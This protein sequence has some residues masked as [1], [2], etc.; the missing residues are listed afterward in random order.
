LRLTPSSTLAYLKPAK[1]AIGP[2]AEQQ[3]KHVALTFR[4]LARQGERLQTDIALATD[5]L[6]ARADSLHPGFGEYGEPA[7]LIYWPLSRTN[8]FQGLLY[9]RGWDHGVAAMPVGDFEVMLEANSD[10]P[11]ICH[12]H[13]LASI[14][15]EQ[16]LTHFKSVLQRLKSQGK[17]ILWTAHNVLPHDVTDID[18]ALR[19]RRAMVEAAD[20]IHIMNPRTEEI[21]APHYTFAA[22]P[23]FHSPHP[24]YAGDQPDTVTRA[25]AR[26][27]LGLS[28]QT[29]VFLSFGSIQPYKGLDDLL[30]AALRLKRDAP[31]LD[32][33]LLIAGEEAKDRGPMLGK[34]PAMEALKERI[35]FVPRKI[36]KN[37]IQ[38]FFRAADYCV[39]PYKPT[40]NSGAA[41]LSLTFGVPIIAP[42]VDAFVDILAEGTG[43]GYA[44][45][46]I[47]ALAAAMGAAAA[48][49]AREMRGRAQAFAMARNP[50][51]ASD[52]FFIGL[53]DRLRTASVTTPDRPSLTLTS[54]AGAGSS[55]PPL[56]PRSFNVP[57]NQGA[58]SVLR[59]PSKQEPQV[60]DGSRIPAPAASR[61]DMTWQAAWVSKLAGFADATRVLEIGTG[62]FTATITLAKNFPS[63][64][65]FGLDFSLRREPLYDPDDL[66]RN[67]NVIRHDRLDLRLFS[68][69]YFSFS[70]SIGAMQHIREL[71][72]HLKQMRRITSPGGYYWIWEAPFWSS[73]MGHH[74]RHSETDCPI[75]H[76]GH[77]Y[78]S[79]RELID[80][81]IAGGR[82][83]DESDKIVTFIYDRSDLS[84]L[85][86]SETKNVINKSRFIVE[87]WE[88]EIDHNYNNNFQEIV[89]A[90]NV[91]NIRLSDLRIKGAKIGLRL[92]E[93][94]VSK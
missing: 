87:S 42:R 68:K 13:W 80:H 26:F 84:R 36:S 29:T 19:V 34:H 1:E 23:I 89:S 69:N 32:W 46:D 66:P 8:N 7:L 60:G 94:S 41:M 57:S 3:G 55:L 65:F 33:V 21:V 30:A 12:F 81:L 71:R 72:D 2:A 83:S 90:N 77:L 20:L 45:N 56:A 79:R 92:P 44:P 4:A 27:E 88:D 93:G 28:A 40:L 54:H 73:S 78:M 59:S 24:S 74:Y 48:T 49:D 11:V 15:S 14:D 62:G 38:Y 76:Y 53:R 39:L 51:K 86:R 85:G 37:D 31:Q 64:Q 9:S 43:L 50:A 52:A 25:E 18:L 82:S 22:T 67:V 6:R 47:D 10:G 75:P 70:F 91:Y 61:Q 5:L 63:K 58:P 35:L 17:L 16:S